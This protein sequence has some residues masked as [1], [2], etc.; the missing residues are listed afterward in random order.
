M[1]KKIWPVIMIVLIFSFPV[2]FAQ[3]QAMTVV[4]LQKKVEFLS[5]MTT[6][7]QKIVL[8]IMEGTEANTNL[9]KEIA[10]IVKANKS[11]YEGNKEKLDVVVQSCDEMVKVNG[12]ILYRCKI[13][14]KN[15]PNAVAPEK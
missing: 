13:K 1:F 12:E 3:D 10:E 11:I 6:E 8:Q 4:E 15:D 2:A 7:L 5:G 9:I 14:L